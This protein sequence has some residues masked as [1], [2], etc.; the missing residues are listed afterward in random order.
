MAAVTDWP[1]DEKKVKRRLVEFHRQQEGSIVHA[2]F[3]PVFPDE[4]TQGAHC[5]S[6]IYWEERGQ[7][8]VTSIDT[9]Q[10]LEG[11][12]AV[13]FTVDEKNRIRRN[14]EGFKPLTVSK[15]KE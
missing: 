13:R 8:F 5:V 2:T 12:V 4:R 6:C 15:Q 3:K 1:E 11:L 14:L 7:C 9:I 10:L